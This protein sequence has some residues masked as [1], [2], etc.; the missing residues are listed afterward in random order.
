MTSSV[1]TGQAPASPAYLHLCLSVN[2]SKGRA[3]LPYLNSMQSSALTYDNAKHL[4]EEPMIAEFSPIAVE[5][6]Q[7]SQKRAT[8]HMHCLLFKS[9]KEFVTYRTARGKRRGRSVARHLRRSCRVPS[10]LSAVAPAHTLRRRVLAKA[11]SW[12]PGGLHSSRIPPG[13]GELAH[14]D[15]PTN[16][17]L[18]SPTNTVTQK[19]CVGVF[20]ARIWQ[21]V[22]GFPHQMAYRH[23]SWVDESHRSICMAYSQICAGNM[24]YY[25]DITSVFV[26]FEVCPFT[27]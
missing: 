24:R 1:Q 23:C 4:R 2:F 20:G 3:N 16:T 13:N 5:T 14:L 15:S 11:E 27:V 8:G 25:A 21:A 17:H 7:S 22:A 6:N 12:I 18:D 9:D 10:V 19:D 26:C